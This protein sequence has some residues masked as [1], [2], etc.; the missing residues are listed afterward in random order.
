MRQNLQLTEQQRSFDP[1]QRRISATDAKGKILNC[2]D[3]FKA[4]SGFTRKELIDSQH[5]I[6][7]HPGMQPH[8]YEHMWRCLK[9]K[10]SWMG[11]VKNCCKIDD[12]YWVDAHITPTFNKAG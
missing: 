4:T 5:N 11:I 3:V 1:S 10:K 7:R 12:Q 8:V 9:A 2:N 6:I